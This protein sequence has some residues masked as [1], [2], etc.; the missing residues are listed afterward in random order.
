MRNL[1]K[2]IL[3][4][5]GTAGFIASGMKA[6]NFTVGKDF[7]DLIW[8]IILFI[9]AAVSFVYLRMLLPDYVE[10]K[11][12]KK[13]GFT[14]KDFNAI[15]TSSIQNAFSDSGTDEDYKEWINSKELKD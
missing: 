6:I 9:G 10:Y 15:S 12:R 1:V 5:S 13:E 7:V 11:K 3:V 14:Q 2:I 8:A 4:L